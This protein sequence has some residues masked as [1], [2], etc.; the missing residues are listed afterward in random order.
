VRGHLA[1]AEGA[2]EIGAFLNGDGEG[3]LDVGF[4]GGIFGH[5]AEVLLEVAEF[6]GL[7]GFSGDP[8]D[9]FADG[10]DQHHGH[11]LFRDAAMGNKMQHLRVGV[12]PVK[13]AGG[14]AEI[15]DGG[16]ENRLPVDGFM[17]QKG[18]QGREHGMSLPEGPLVGQAFMGEMLVL[19]DGTGLSWGMLMRCL[20]LGIGLVGGLTGCGR[21]LPPFEPP[22]QRAPYQQVRATAYTHSERDHWKHG[23]LSAMGTAL[24]S[25]EMNSAA[26]DWSRWPAGTVF[27]VMETGQLYQ[28][29]DYGWA[30]SGTNTIDLYMSDRASMNAWGVRRV[31]L[32]ILHWGDLD[33]SW[34]VLYPR[35]Q[36]K[37]VARMLKQ[38]RKS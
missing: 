29:D 11:D 30:L 1:D 32:Q 9:A 24:R 35:R 21:P 23:R 8:G 20:V 17:A 22:M 28:V 4:A 31:N 13:C 36:H 12:Q 3:T 37:H 7:S 6:N 18:W 26:A 34:R 2:A 5:S 19:K 27:R 25:G 10:N 15:F 16:V 38:M 14:A 33:E